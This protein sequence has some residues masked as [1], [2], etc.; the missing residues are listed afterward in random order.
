MTSLVLPIIRL[1][2]PKVPPM[3]RF[4]SL[5]I[6][7][8]GVAVVASANNFA[9]GKLFARKQGYNLDSNTVWRASSKENAVY[10][11]GKLY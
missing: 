7:A 9:M 5:Y 4:D 6:D 2:A 3:S 11:L 10:Y 8:I 1:P